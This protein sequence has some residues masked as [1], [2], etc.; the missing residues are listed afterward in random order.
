MKDVVINLWQ[1]YTNWNKA[2]EKI[3]LAEAQRI[4][5]AFSLSLR[6]IYLVRVEYH[7]LNL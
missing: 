5:S 4:F 1:R 7:Y 6:E 3:I 2:V